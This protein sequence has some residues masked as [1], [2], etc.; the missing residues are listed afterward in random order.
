MPPAE[1]SSRTHLWRHLILLDF[2]RVCKL[3]FSGGRQPLNL[4]DGC[5]HQGTII[6]ELMHAI[7]FIHEHSNVLSLES[8]KY[9][10]TEPIEINTSVSYG[11]TLRKKQNTTL[12][13]GMPAAWP[14]WTLATLM[15]PSCTT[16]ELHS[17]KC[18]SILFTM[19]RHLGWQVA[20]SCTK[21][22]GFKAGWRR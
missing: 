6:H 16:L 10:K 14:L 15:I 1:I 12:K 3:S 19:K 22:D 7:G 4:G 18:V 20:Y 8:L 2:Y 5:Y 11:P 13:R 21:K 9:F 17:A